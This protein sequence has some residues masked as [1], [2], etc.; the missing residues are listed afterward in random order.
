[1]PEEVFYFTFGSS[2]TYPFYGGWA[3]VIAKDRDDAVRKFN[4]KYPPVEDDLVRCAFIYPQHIFV[5]TQMFL[6][7]NNLGE[8]CHIVI[9]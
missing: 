2:S 8:A 1:M 4:E 7:G 3:K 6:A 9:E 5:Q